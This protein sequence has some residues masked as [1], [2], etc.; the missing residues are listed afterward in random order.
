MNKIL[1]QLNKEERGSEQ[2]H[3]VVSG[4]F[5]DTISNIMEVALRKLNDWANSCGLGINSK[6]QN[7]C[8]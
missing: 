5:A 3:V 4:P 1:Q 2:Y 7:Q 8:F 6:I